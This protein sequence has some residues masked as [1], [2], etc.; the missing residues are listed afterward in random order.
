MLDPDADSIN[1]K[2]SLSD[3][4]NSNFAKLTYLPDIMSCLRAG[5]TTSTYG[6]SSD[7]MPLADSPS[8]MTVVAG[9]VTVGVVA[10]YGTVGGVTE[11]G[12]VGGMAAYIIV[13]GVA[14]YGIVDGTAVDV[15]VGGVVKCGIV[16]GMAVGCIVGGVA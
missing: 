11:Y 9:N 16:D 6:I 15:I 10:E 13:G 3:S 8:E 1:L 5:V 2:S 12:T 4:G 7:A 14:T